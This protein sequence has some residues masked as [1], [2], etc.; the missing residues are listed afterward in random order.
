MRHNFLSIRSTVRKACALLW[1][2]VPVALL[3][4]LGSCS[5]KS[6]RFKIEGRFLHLNQ[7][8]VLVYSPDGGIDGL[9]TIQIQGGRFVYETAMRDPSTLVL[10]FPNFSEQPIFAEPGEAVTV[11]AD[12]S[13]L[14]EME[15]KGTKDNE[16]M[17]DFRQLLAKNSPL[18]AP[19]LTTDF[20]EEH[21]ESR[22]GLYLVSTY[23]V[24]GDQPSYSEALRL[25]G[26]MR[27]E[28][29]RN[30]QLIR[31]EKQLMQY[32][33]VKVGQP[34]PAFKATTLDGQ[35]FTQQ[36]FLK[37]SGVVV[38]WASWSYE[39]LGVLRTLQDI[40]DK[41]PE[42]QVLTICADATRKEC[43]RAM[44]RMGIT[45][46]TFCDGR[47]VDCPLLMQLSLNY[48]PDNIVVENGRVKSRSMSNADLRKKFLEN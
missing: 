39:S 19:R 8:Q 12:A 16:R 22:V 20:V 10:V 37:G 38:A 7:G 48:I 13:H 24:R 3:L 46:P 31:L 41:H 9:D 35:T 44:E 47:M 17:T 6:G 5:G 2:A 42:L 4:T 1:L 25:I 40:K 18:D 26:L 33:Q 34:L 27:K 29:P 36:N 14:R 30:G 45:L 43:G 23:L 28:Q 21:P 15:V 32:R 11:K